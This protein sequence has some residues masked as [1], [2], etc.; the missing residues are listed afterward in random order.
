MNLMNY[1]ETA[2][3]LKL[4]KRTLYSLVS[5]E[6]VPILPNVFPRKRLF[7]RDAIDHWLENGAP[8]NWNKLIKDFYSQKAVTR[9]LCLKC[10]G[11][12]TTHT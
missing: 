9:S 6:R 5:R 12:L 8:E 1:E 10:A 7:D 2:K 11:S 4:Q 3:Y